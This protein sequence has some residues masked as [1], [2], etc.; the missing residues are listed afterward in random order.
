MRLIGGIAKEEGGEPH[1]L[2]T[3]GHSGCFLITKAG[4]KT[5]EDVE[6]CLRYLDRMNSQEMRRLMNYGLEG[7]DYEIDEEG[8][9]VDLLSDM[10][11]S[12]KPQSGLN[13][14][15][16]NLTS[17][18]PNVKQNERQLTATAVI[19][20]NI[21]IAVHNPASGY[22]LGSSVYTESGSDL[23]DIISRAR[24]Q[25]IVGQ[26]DEEGLKEQFKVWEQRGGSDLIE[27]INEL[28][29]ADK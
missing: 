16:P 17:L 12:A 3:S 7:R 26:L 2:A 29:N 13:Q 9:I 22:L 24:T 18:N 8:Y 11:A 20:S 15:G 28:Y 25:Y 1:T 6:A 14:T 4:A 27:E 21:K 10:E 23:N 19:E 5:E